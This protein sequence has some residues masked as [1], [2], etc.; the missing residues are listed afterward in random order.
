MA[1]SFF[2]TCCAEETG[3]RSGCGAAA[4]AALGRVLTCCAPLPLLSVRSSSEWATHTSCRAAR[5]RDRSVLKCSV[6]SGRSGTF[7]E[8]RR[9][10]EARG[11]RLMKRPSAAHP[12]LIQKHDHPL[13]VVFDEGV[14]AL[15]VGL[16]CGHKTT[17]HQAV[18]PW[19]LYATFNRSVL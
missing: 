13:F 5:S 18:G 17:S 3:V 2:S 14:D 4:A 6:A 8:H 15:H 9:E 12:Q 19:L 7:C 16:L 11:A 10:G 1:S